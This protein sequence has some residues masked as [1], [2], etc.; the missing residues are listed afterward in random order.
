MWKC[1]SSKRDKKIIED[2]KSERAQAH[3]RKC[4]EA[5]KRIGVKKK[6]HTQ[7]K[8]AKHMKEVKNQLQTYNSR[9][10]TNQIEN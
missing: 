6:K 8:R 1:I 4:D 10:F 2:G 9:S 3:W 5:N 7:R